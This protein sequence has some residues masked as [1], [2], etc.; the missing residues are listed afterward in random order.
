MKSQKQKVEESLLI[1]LEAAK[2]EAETQ[3]FEEEFDKEKLIL[4]ACKIVEDY[5]SL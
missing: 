4:S 1:V 2:Q 3:K 5:Y